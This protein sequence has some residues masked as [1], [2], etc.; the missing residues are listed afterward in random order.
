MTLERFLE[1]VNNK[2]YEKLNY[3]HEKNARMLLY[4]NYIDIY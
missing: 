1:I 2:E 4:T 3:K